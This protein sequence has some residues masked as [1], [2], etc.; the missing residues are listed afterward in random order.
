MTKNVHPELF[1]EMCLDPVSAN[2]EKGRGSRW[3]VRVGQRLP[4]R[5][6]QSGAARELNLV[7]IA[8]IEFLTICRIPEF[9]KSEQNRKI[10]RN[11][12]IWRKWA[13]V[14]RKN[15]I[16]LN[17]SFGMNVCRNFI[18]QAALNPPFFVCGVLF[19]KKSL[20]TDPRS[21][22]CYRRVLGIF[23]ERKLSISV[24]LLVLSP[25]ISS[26]YTMC[27]SGL[28][29]PMVAPADGIKKS[30]RSYPMK[31]LE[32]ATCILMCA[33]SR[34]WFASVASWREKQIA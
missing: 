32:D 19:V 22:W 33:C 26:K 18:I 12:R 9:P 6:V 11:V 8:S 4:S 28:M 13:A 17:K 21:L 15:H 25:E 7:Q 23:I 2:S 1:I 29:R 30:V 31:G 20:S 27:G 24:V 34:S 5:F 10:C 14:L 3:A 16:N